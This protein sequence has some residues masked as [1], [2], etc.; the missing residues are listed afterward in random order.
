[1]NRPGAEARVLRHAGGGSGPAR[2]AHSAHGKA[3]SLCATAVW[4]AAG[5][6]GGPGSS[7]LG[8]GGCLPATHPRW[9]LVGG[10]RRGRCGRSEPASRPAL[11]PPRPTGQ[12]PRT[13]EGWM[14]RG[15]RIIGGAG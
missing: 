4:D 5:A 3:T 11:P 15:G 10:G 14:P 7:S 13:E 6:A 9:R 2:Q 8:E 1:M 12:S